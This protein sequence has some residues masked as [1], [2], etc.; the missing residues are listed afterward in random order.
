[1]F[2]VWVVVCKEVTVIYVGLNIDKYPYG[3]YSDKGLFAGNKNDTAVTVYRADWKIPTHR[4]HFLPNPSLDPTAG[5]PDLPGWSLSQPHISP[6][7]LAEL[8]LRIVFI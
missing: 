5:L 1:M 3:I 7:D 8:T 6:R 2:V 4:F